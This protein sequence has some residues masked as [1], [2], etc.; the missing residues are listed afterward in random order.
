MHS[1]HR[2]T[3]IQETPGSCPELVQEEVCD[4]DDA[5]ARLDAALHSVQR[6]GHEAG[7]TKCST[8][9]NTR[10]TILDYHFAFTHSALS[11]L[12]FMRY[13]SAALQHGSKFTF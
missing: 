6:G 1:L 10:P 8:A 12:V 13:M 9:S 2:P 11:S 5:H 7:C 3:P 4:A